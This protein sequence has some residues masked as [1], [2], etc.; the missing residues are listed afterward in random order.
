MA[1][2]G[3]AAVCASHGRAPAANARAIEP[4]NT[5]EIVF[6]LMLVTPDSH[7]KGRYPRGAANCLTK[8]QQG[9]GS[10]TRF[11]RLLVPW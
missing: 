11:P 2:T 3:A 9:S 10:T 6:A 5:A 8:V 7:S 4:A 1:A